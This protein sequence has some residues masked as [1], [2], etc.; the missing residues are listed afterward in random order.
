MTTTATTATTTGNKAIIQRLYE[1]VV[2]R[3]RP[4]A[5]DELVATDFVVH[6]DGTDDVDPVTG[7]DA[8]RAGARILKAACADFEIHI[9]QMVAE[10]DMVT[11][12]WTSRGTHTGEFLGHPPTGRVVGH[13]GVVMY[14]LLDGRVVE[15]WPMVDRLG[16]LQQM[17]IVAPLPGEP[18]R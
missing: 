4:E 11:V 10:G 8:F 6:G 7:P 1:E 13:W 17:G 5:A 3:D 2:N 9:R 18:E 12:R 14:R 15:M 16:I